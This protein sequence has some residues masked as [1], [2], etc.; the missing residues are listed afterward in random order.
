V[1]IKYI[2]LKGNS[3]KNNYDNMLVTLG[4][5]HPSYSIFKNWVARFKIGHLSTEDFVVVVVG[6]TQFIC[7]L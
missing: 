4:D 1:V 5:K 3:A 6:E 7:S 2:Y